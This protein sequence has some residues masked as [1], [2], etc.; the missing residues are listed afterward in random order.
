MADGD[1][2][3]DRDD[4]ERALLGAAPAIDPL[5]RAVALARVSNGLFSVATQVT[6]GRY[7]L[8]ERVGAG[9]MG[10]VW[11]AWDPDLERRVAI[12]LVKTRQAESRAR[13]LAEGQALAR[14][15]HPHVVPVYDVGVIDDHVYLVMEWVSGVTLRAYVVE[16]RTTREIVGVYRQAG[17]GLAAAHAAGLIH[18]DF[19][20][21]N[22]V[23]G[24]DGRTRVLDFGLSTMHRDAGGRAASPGRIAGTPRYMAP[25]Q[26]AGSAE[27]T[28]AVDQFAF[29]RALEEAVLHRGGA[30][31]PRWLAAIVAR[32]TAAQP[33]ARFPSMAA[34]LAQLARD[35]RT[36]WRRRLVAGG[37]IALA[38]AM[39]AIGRAREDPPR[40][41]GAADALAPS[42]NT[43]VRARLVD[44]LRALDPFAAAAA[45]RVAGNLDARAGDWLRVHQG[46]CLAYGRGELTTALYERRLACLTRARVELAT[47]AEV[48]TAA[49]MADVGD[50]LVAEQ[51]LPSPTT[52]DRAD[53]SGIAAPV[54]ALAPAADLAA[55][56]VTRAGILVEAR[57]SEAPAAARAAL[58]HA[59]AVAYAPTVARA[60]LV[61]GRAEAE[62]DTP[63]AADAAARL[64]RAFTVALAAHDD[65]LAVEAFARLT[66]VNG[67]DGR[68]VE[69]FA[70]VEQL[71]KRGGEQTRFVRALLYNNLAVARL[72]GNDRAGA[73]DMLG[74]A[75]V[76][77]RPDAIGDIELISVPLNLALIATDPD[78]RERLASDAAA[79][80]ERRL[81][82]DH[83]RTLDA[84]LLVGLLTRNPRVAA[85]RLQD[86]CDRYRSMHSHL[87]IQ[88]AHCTFEVGWLAAELGD[89]VA[90]AAAMRRVASSSTEDRDKAEIAAGFAEV[91]AG[92]AGGAAL[93]RLQDRAIRLAARDDWYDRVNGADAYAA[94]A[95]GWEALGRG[96]DAASAWT[97]ALAI[98]ERVDLPVYER[99]LARARAA[100]ARHLVARD[101][102][103]ARRHAGA[104]LAWYR[105]AGG[106]DRDVRE[107]EA[108]MESR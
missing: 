52:C 92:S 87:A 15:S 60:L 107:L 94:A 18:C 105:A 30:E 70:I 34:L 84:R 11:G 42:W 5:T 35:P 57:R 56:E 69:G 80:L 97:A 43:G 45:D 54:P 66:W 17:E 2:E 79:E 65:T 61:L 13:I 26:A 27:L 24:K 16:P 82:P 33:S 75:M 78:R 25:E 104:A 90:A 31:L 76:E 48:L 55:Q 58:A 73:L 32:A 88:V 37:A 3:P 103:V 102:D 21:D 62:T 50:A 53:V 91:L 71:A 1:P 29:G 99:R 100:A 106:Y 77:R 38:V 20:P 98:L 46:A 6:L 59:E 63:E 44:H 86:A 10:V 23:V 83:P 47:V 96:G 7:H 41:S 85:H 68:G 81:G 14:L 74:R 108:I 22:A 67:R 49:R 12:K 4:D 93:V 8:L 101:R 39:F 72:D 9:G 28:A 64:G 89:P 36:V 51:A 40:C 95:V 19:K